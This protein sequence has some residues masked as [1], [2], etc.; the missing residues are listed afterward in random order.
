MNRK[1]IN[2]AVREVLTAQSVITP[3]EVS[4]AVVGDRKMRLLN[5]KYR[6]LD[7]TTN[8]LSFSLTEGDK[9][10]TP[11]AK[12]GGD[13]LMR[14]GDIVI[15]YPQVIRESAKEEVLVDDKIDELVVHSLLHL[16]GLHHE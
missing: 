10:V 12:N 2:K 11:P 4:I 16:L 8:V 3:A 6:G 14:L 9:I 13:S 7:K 5:N 15:S 1:R